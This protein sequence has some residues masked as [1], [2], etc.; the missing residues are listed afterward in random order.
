MSYK[1][2]IDEVGRGCWAGPL[3][4]VAAK[5]RENCILPI[6]LAD[7]KTLSK[8]KRELL[9]PEIVESCV[10]GE[11]WVQPEEIDKYGLSKGMRIGVARA[12]ME[13]GTLTD[14]HILMDGVTNYCPPEFTN[15]EVMAKADSISPIVSAASIYAKVTR[16]RH[17]FRAAKF[18]P[19]YGFEKHV[20]YGTRLHM[21]LLKLHGVSKIH[22]LSYKPVQALLT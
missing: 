22:R 21:D 15:V 5:V 11:G 6:G 18:Y 16:D 13:L 10:L 2:G 7:S 12:L 3:L 14:E 17:M 1:V 9:Y 8:M 4:I 20:G 19:F